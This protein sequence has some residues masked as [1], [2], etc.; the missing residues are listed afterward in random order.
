MAPAAMLED[1]V[2]PE[3][4]KFEARAI[5]VA[6]LAMAMATSVSAYVCGSITMLDGAVWL[7]LRNRMTNM[8][9]DLVVDP[10]SLPP[11]ESIF[12]IQYLAE[13]LA[14]QIDPKLYEK[15]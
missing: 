3:V 8:G 11:D 7:R 6:A 1:R 12:S 9:I 2:T 10:V 15:R 13:R 14:Q 4:F 5:A